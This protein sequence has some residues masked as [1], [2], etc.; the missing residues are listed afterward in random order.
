MS[1]L[2]ILFSILAIYSLNLTFGQD[3]Q[4]IN[5]RIIY[6][7]DFTG[8]KPGQEVIFLNLDSDGNY[9][10]EGNSIHLKKSTV[11]VLIVWENKVIASGSNIHLLLREN[12]KEISESGTS[13]CLKTNNHIDLRIGNKTF[14]NYELIPYSYE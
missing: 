10:F 2:K 3:C 14:L 7:I 5:T 1:T 4:K 8:S 13:A 12:E 9:S 11:E 6:D